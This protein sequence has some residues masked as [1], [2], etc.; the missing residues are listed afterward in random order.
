MS[1]AHNP[2]R[3]RSEDRDPALTLAGHG[4]SQIVEEHPR[5]PAD[6]HTAPAGIPAGQGPSA[7]ELEDRWRRAVAEL[8]NLRKRFER[9]LAEQARA[10]RARTAAAFLPVLDNLELALRHASAD[11]TAILTGVQAV[12]AQALEVL[13]GLGY[14]RIGP[15]GERF[16]PARH[17]AARV[18]P[19][20]EGVE[21]GT[22]VEVH[23]H[24]LIDG[25]G[26][27]VRPAVVT[28]AQASESERE[29][30]EE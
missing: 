25:A 23:R 5:V 17:E 14:R 7:A 16:D 19:A 13:G 9:Q 27:L 20:A 4:D 30:Q 2:A 3:Q 1:S 15:V 26:M 11:P 18:V 6:A 22:V 29:S 24:G 12:H 21:S 8:D 10:E 28:V